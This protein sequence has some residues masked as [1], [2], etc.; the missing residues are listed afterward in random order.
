[1]NEYDDID[2]KL[3]LTCSVI[4]FSL[5]EKTLVIQTFLEHWT[6]IIF[7]NKWRVKP[8]GRTQVRPWVEPVGRPARTRSRLGR[9]IARPAPRRGEKKS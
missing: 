8:A 5:I 1:M 7:C 6:H 4:R 3:T 9:R 2:V